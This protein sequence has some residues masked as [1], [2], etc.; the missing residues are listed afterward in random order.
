MVEIGFPRPDGY[1][2]FW[3][4]TNIEEHKKELGISTKKKSKHADEEM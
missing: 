4:D 2:G 3:T 1:Y